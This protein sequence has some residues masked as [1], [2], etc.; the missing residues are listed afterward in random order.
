MAK[1]S[2]I[3]QMSEICRKHSL[4]VIW[5]EDKGDDPWPL[6]ESGTC[7]VRHAGE[8]LE[9]FRDRILHT[10]QPKRKIPKAARRGITRGRST[11]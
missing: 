10:V 9:A 1:G 6:P 3:S 2:I 7:F 8:S 5:V 11:K 4:T